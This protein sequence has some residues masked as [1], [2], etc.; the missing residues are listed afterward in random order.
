[1]TDQVAEVPDERRIKLRYAG[2]C[3]RCD[4]E[5]PART[6]AIHQ[7][8]TKSVQCLACHEAGAAQ[9]PPVAEEPWRWVPW[10]RCH[11]SRFRPSLRRL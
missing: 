11:L 8:S 9:R 3:R 10:V 6:E 1:M 5:L 4:K 2:V 7:R